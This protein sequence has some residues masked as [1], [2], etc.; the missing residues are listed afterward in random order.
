MPTAENLDEALHDET[1]VGDDITMVPE[2]VSEKL[3]E[4]PL[5]EFEKTQLKNGF[6]YEY[7]CQECEST[8]TTLVNISIP[9]PAKH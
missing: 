8:F 4:H 9:A 2:S 1:A 5:S 7:E 6:E 3:C